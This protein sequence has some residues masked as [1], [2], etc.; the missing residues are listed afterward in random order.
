MIIAIPSSIGELIDKITILEIKKIKFPQD[1]EKT[2]NILKE[3]EILSN[4]LNGLNLEIEYNI[5]T[6]KESLFK[7]NLSLW[8]TEDLLRQ[9]ES[10]K[11]FDT[12]FIELARSV[13]FTNDERARLKK[14]INITCNSQIIEE[15]HYIEYN[16]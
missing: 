9:H 6:L 1:S 2:V 8:H 14:E 16:K 12:D 15:K 4:V 7:V 13:Y 10:V 3:L 5:T 11:L